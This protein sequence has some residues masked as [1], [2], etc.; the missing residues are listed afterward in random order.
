MFSWKTL[1]TGVVK[2]TLSPR[3]WAWLAATALT[4]H[5]VYR[6]GE[7]AWLS[8]LIVCWCIISVFFLGGKAFQDAL[9]TMV[10]DR[11]D[12]DVKVGK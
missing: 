2:N 12:V 10:R 9:N 6:D 11:M 1:V 5:G 3:T 7:H 4:W 8:T